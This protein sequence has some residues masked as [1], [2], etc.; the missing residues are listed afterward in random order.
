MLRRGRYVGGCAN[1]ESV[2]RRNVLR[3]PLRPDAI[4]VTCEAAGSHDVDR[5]C[6]VHPSGERAGVADTDVVTTGQHRHARAADRRELEHDVRQ[7]ATGMNGYDNVSRQNLNDIQRTCHEREPSCQPWPT[8][9]ERLVQRCGRGRH[10]RVDGQRARR[11]VIED[12]HQL[13][14]QPVTR[15]EIDDA[16]AAKQPAHTARGFP[17]FIQLLAWETPGMA[18]GAADPIEKCFTWE[19]RKISIGEAAM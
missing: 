12:Q 8:F 9:D 10:H 4:S 2:L 11:R 18:G 19:A 13:R 17:C 15:S 16:A 5:E 7:P 14:E 3:D 1:Q 6:I